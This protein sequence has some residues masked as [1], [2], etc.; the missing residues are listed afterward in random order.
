MGLT[1]FV[2]M[3][4][5]GLFYIYFRLLNYKQWVRKSI[6]RISRA[7]KRSGHIYAVRGR[8]ESTRTIKLGR[9]ITMRGRMR[10][11]RTYISPWGVYIAGCCHVRDDKKAENWIKKHFAR[12]RVNTRNEWFRYS[13][14]IRLF[15]WAIKDHRLT[16]KEQ[17]RW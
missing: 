12:E 7:S 11:A 5:L 4:V 17:S 1:V 6:G 3:V 2:A 10:S 9:T 13:I 16:K 8:R 14:R 15:V